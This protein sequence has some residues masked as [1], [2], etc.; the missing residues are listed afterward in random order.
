[1]TVD[2]ET[3]KLIDAGHLGIYTPADKLRVKAAWTKATVLC[4]RHLTKENRSRHWICAGC[5]NLKA[6]DHDTRRWRCRNGHLNYDSRTMWK[7]RGPAVVCSRCAGHPR[8]ASNLLN[9]AFL[10]GNAYRKEGRWPQAELLDLFRQQ[11]M[12]Q[13]PKD[14][15]TK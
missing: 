4:Y 2:P 3:Q 9:K 6:K 1:M 7:V 11:Y 12:I 13:L 15:P 10:A 5:V 14:P 8:L